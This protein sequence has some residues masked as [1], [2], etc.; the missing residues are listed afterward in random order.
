[1]RNGDDRRLRK[2]LPERSLDQVVSCGIHRSSGFVQNKDLA[3]FQNYLTKADKLTL[4]Y[5]P[6]L[7]ILYHCNP[8]QEDFRRREQIPCAPILAFWGKFV[9][10]AG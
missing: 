8:S 9:K 10:G 4:A 2:L 6:V 7:T 1:V 3:P 5:T